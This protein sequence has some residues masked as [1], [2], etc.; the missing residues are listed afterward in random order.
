MICYRNSDGKYTVFSLETLECTLTVRAL[1]YSIKFTFNFIGSIKLFIK[2]FN[3]HDRL[4]SSGPKVKSA[5]IHLIIEYDKNESLG[6]NLKST[7]ANRFIVHADQYNPVLAAH[8]SF[9]MLFDD[10][11]KPDILVV[12]GLQ[13]MEG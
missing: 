12:G 6:E 8:D 9:K 4:K 13:M 2:E 1:H 3:L 7:R 11:D 10:A 5:D